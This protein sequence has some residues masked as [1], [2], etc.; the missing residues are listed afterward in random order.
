[1]LIDG[2]PGDVRVAAAVEAR[3]S[4]DGEETPAGGAVSRRAEGR[5][6]D[7]SAEAKTSIVHG[8]VKGDE[9]IDVAQGQ[10]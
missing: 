4:G 2:S 8:R 7:N 9:R 1:M 6:P 10:R 5:V 3:G